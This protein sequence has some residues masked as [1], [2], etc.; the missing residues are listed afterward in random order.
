MF[1]FFCFLFLFLSVVSFQ[2]C[3][4]FKEKSLLQWHLPMHFFLKPQVTVYISG[5]VTIHSLKINTE[6]AKLQSNSTKFK[7]ASGI[8]IRFEQIKTTSCELRIYTCIHSACLIA[9]EFGLLFY[10]KLALPLANFAVLLIFSSLIR[11]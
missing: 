9:K 5:S 4:C 3:N 10:S 8:D 2:P 1:S 7:L 6:S 11:S